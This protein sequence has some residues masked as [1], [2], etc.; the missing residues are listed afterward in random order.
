MIDNFRETGRPLLAVL[1]DPKSIFIRGLRK[2]KQRSLYANIINDRTAPFYTTGI[3]K[4]DPFLDLTVVNL[5]Y[6]E[7]YND[8]ILDPVRGF[9]PKE[10]TKLNFSS[11]FTLKTS[12]LINNLPLFIALIFLIPIGTL[13]FLVNAAVQTISSS[14]RIQLHE[15]G[16]AGIDLSSYRMPFLTDIREVVEDVY[17]NLNNAQSQEYLPVN[18]DGVRSIQGEFIPRDE[19]LM[20]DESTEKLHSSTSETISGGHMNSQFHQMEAPVLALTPEQFAMIQTLDDVGWR[21][22]LVHI[23]KVRHSHAAILV[24]SDRQGFSEGY[25]VLRHLVEEFL[26]E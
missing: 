20:V 1:A 25:I 9:S 8:V 17:E 13:A 11:R 21:K 24:R 6:L 3:F 22:Y 26:M 19:P 5:N 15:S 14:R 2:F 10:K 7:G 23:H 12:N 4:I 16:Q 18:Q